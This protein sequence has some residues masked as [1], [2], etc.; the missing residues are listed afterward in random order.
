MFM[1][2]SL[3]SKRRSTFFR[4]AMICA[5]LVGAAWGGPLSARGGRGMGGFGMHGLAS[6]REGFLTPAYVLITVSKIT[7]TEAFKTTIRDLASGTAPFAARLAADIDKP[8]SWDGTAV[9]HVVLLEFDNPDQAQAWKNSGVFKKFEGDLHRSSE[10]SMQLVQ[11]LPTPVGR[12][13]EGGRG[14]RGHGRLDPKAFEP[15]VKEYDQMLNKM[16]G[17]CKGC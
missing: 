7:D 5:L 12:G 13:M 10:S 15:N 4:S 8:A 1:P 2:G 9:E 14:G 16:H 3:A 11:G 6:G 17:I